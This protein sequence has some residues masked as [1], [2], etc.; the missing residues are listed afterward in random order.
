[1]LRLEN[2]VCK[3]ENVNTTSLLPFVFVVAPAEGAEVKT[4]LQIYSI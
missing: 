2:R 3:S 4:K 1:M